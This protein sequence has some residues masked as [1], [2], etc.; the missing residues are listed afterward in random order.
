MASVMSSQSSSG[1]HDSSSSSGSS[2][3][4]GF[5]FNGSVYPTYEEMVAAKRERNRKV[6]QKSV[7]D[8]TSVLGTDA[9]GSK[10]SSASSK[11]RKRRG[12]NQSATGSAPSSLRRN[13]KRAARS[14]TSSISSQSHM[15]VSSSCQPRPREVD[16]CNLSTNIQIQNIP[17]PEI[18]N[19]Q[20]EIIEPC[21][22]IGPGWT[23]RVRARKKVPV[24]PDAPT[25]DRVFYSPTGKMLRSLVK[26]QRYIEGESKRYIE[27]GSA[28]SGNETDGTSVFSASRSCAP[29]YLNS[30]A[31]STPKT[32]NDN[33]RMHGAPMEVVTV[34]SATAMPDP[35]LLSSKSMVMKDAST[36]LEHVLLV[37]GN[38]KA[39]E[40]VW[41]E[42]VRSNVVLGDD[43]NKQCK[44]SAKRGNKSKHGSESKGRD[45]MIHLGDWKL[46]HPVFAKAEHGSQIEESCKRHDD[47]N[48]NVM[49][50]NDTD[51][52][53]SFSHDDIV[54]PDEFVVTEGEPESTRIHRHKQEQHQRFLNKTMPLNDPVKYNNMVR[55]MHSDYTSV[56]R[57][58]HW[59]QEFGDGIDPMLFAEECCQRGAAASGSDD[60]CSPDRPREGQESGDEKPSMSKVHASSLL[61]RCWDR[62]VH[63]ASS[64][65]SAISA[66]RQMTPLPANIKREDDGVAVQNE[67]VASSILH[68]EAMNVVNSLLFFLFENNGNKNT[69]GRML[70]D[71]SLTGKNKIDWRHVLKCLKIA[72]VEDNEAK[73]VDH[74]L[75]YPYGST[76]IQGDERQCPMP[77][78]HV[79]LKALSMRLI[80]RYGTESHKMPL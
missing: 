2:S 47:N 28:M 68:H 5:A 62:A 15:S 22:Q 57:D 65:F 9:N 54:I 36:V 13:P 73:T 61:Q 35:V 74:E 25:V 46:Y 75:N 19:G 43:D 53:C 16:M 55:K 10:T 63:A 78:N 26:V 17:I 52:F 29:D 30:V 79:T 18:P 8:L 77:L 69:L 59:D 23:M 49:N 32:K 14:T 3:V 21:P 60:D 71:I 42:S 51:G 7:D 24:R 4:S 12:S 33:I 67:S 6:L 11:K 64:T 1:S 80:E 44:A 27:G 72:S 45:R 56:G 50:K 20:T 38:V 31:L 66:S 48:E 58:R 34:A 41:R 40:E 37:G 70:D 76:Q 39:R